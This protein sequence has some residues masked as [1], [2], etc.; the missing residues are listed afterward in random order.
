MAV[1][2]EARHKLYRHVEEDWG[3][4][5]ANTLM[6]HLPPGGWANVAT[7]DDIASLRKDTD[8]GF[9]ALRKDMDHE[10]GLMDEKIDHKFAMVDLKFEAMGDKVDKAVHEVTSDL[11]HR[12][13]TFVFAMLGFLSIV[14]SIVAG[15]IVAL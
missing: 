8:D 4:D 12:Q 10:F 5:V 11:L 13:L 14:G 9:A 7:K 2:E 1:T 15:V 6:D 3:E